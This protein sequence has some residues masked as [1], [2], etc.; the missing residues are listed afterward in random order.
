M[1]RQKKLCDSVRL[2][3]VM[4]KSQAERIKQMAIRLSQQEGRVVTVSE[5]IRS[6]LEAA[7][8]VPKTQGKL[9]S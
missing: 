5:A 9:F 1:G 3:V 8:P 2:S 6:V 7:Y 4:S